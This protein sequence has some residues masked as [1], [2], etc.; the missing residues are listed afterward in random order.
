[1]GRS[2]AD[3]MAGGFRVQGERGESHKFSLIH[4]IVSITCPPPSLLVLV[5]CCP[6]DAGTWAG[7]IGQA[8]PVTENHTFASMTFLTSYKGQFQVTSRPLPYVSANQNTEQPQD[9]QKAARKS[10]QGLCSRAESEE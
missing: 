6:V 2:H 9:A 5:G 4:P 1:M 8:A 3:H 7:D 10:R